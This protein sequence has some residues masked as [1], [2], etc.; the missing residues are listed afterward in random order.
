MD[1]IRSYYY[2]LSPPRAETSPRRRRSV[3]E[4]DQKARKIGKTAKAKTQR[5]LAS[6][7]IVN[8]KSRIIYLFLSKAIPVQPESVETIFLVRRFTPTIHAS[9]RL[10]LNSSRQDARG[11]SLGGRGSVGVVLIIHAYTRV[12]V[13]SY[14]VPVS[15][16]VVTRHEPTAGAHLALSLQCTP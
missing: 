9:A 11:R 4:V 3:A 10:V 6:L 8:R 14:R 2:H 12:H 1:H 5:P 15:P 7:Q 16:A 13:S